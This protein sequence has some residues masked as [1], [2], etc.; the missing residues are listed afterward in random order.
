MLCTLLDH[1]SFVPPQL[2]M[3]LS[4]MDILNSPLLSFESSISARVVILGRRFP[5]KIFG[6]ICSADP[7]YCKNVC[8]PL[9]MAPFL[10]LLLINALGR[11]TIFKQN[12]FFFLALFVS[13]SLF[14]SFSL[15]ILFFKK[16]MR[17]R[18]VWE[19]RDNKSKSSSKPTEEKSKFPLLFAH[20]GRP[21]GH[22]TIE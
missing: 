21:L 10:F 2:Y 3:I 16:R 6:R 8:I 12:R 20:L 18:D 1:C 5:A 11:K 14:V 13:L 19:E 9:M 4:L 22:V 7:M 17:M 15:S